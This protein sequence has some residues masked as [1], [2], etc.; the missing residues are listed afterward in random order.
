[1]EGNKANEQQKKKKK[2]V[3]NTEQRQKTRIHNQENIQRRI[4]VKLWTPKTGN[5]KQIINS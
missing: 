4:P 1:M 5:R 3:Q 2:K